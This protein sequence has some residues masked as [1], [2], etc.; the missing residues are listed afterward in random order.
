MTAFEGIL[1]LNLILIYIGLF[2]LVKLV[3]E[4]KK[5]VDRDINYEENE[6]EEINLWRTKDDFKN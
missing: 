4:L 2:R 6:P 3:S 1:S 5:D